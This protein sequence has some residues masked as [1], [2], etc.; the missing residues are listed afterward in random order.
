MVT[1]MLYIIIYLFQ[2]KYDYNKGIAPQDSRKRLHGMK[3]DNYVF[4]RTIT[5]PSF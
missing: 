5:S 2:L 1:I 3:R 4:Q